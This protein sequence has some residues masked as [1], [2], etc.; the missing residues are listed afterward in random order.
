MAENNGRVAKDVISQRLPRQVEHFVVNVVVVF[1]MEVQFLHLLRDLVLE[2]SVVAPRNLVLVA[3]EVELARLRAAAAGLADVQDDESRTANAVQH[4][5][6]EDSVLALVTDQLTLDLRN[7]EAVELEIVVVVVEAVVVV[8]D[9]EGDGVVTGDA[10]R[11]HHA[12]LG[13]GL[14]G[15]AE[16][17]DGAVGRVVGESSVLLQRLPRGPDPVR[18]RV[19]QVEDGVVRREAERRHGVQLVP[20]D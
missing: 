10:V 9:V 19:H 11:V 7:G 6:C 1:G 15:F 8:E 12:G 14:Q 2:E 20:A 16:G 4:E 5:A 17:R 18:G 3:Q 13:E